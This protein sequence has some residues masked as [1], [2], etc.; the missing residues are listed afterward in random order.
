MLDGREEVERPRNNV[1]GEGFFDSTDQHGWNHYR[2]PRLTAKISR[3][4]A[5]E[6]TVSGGWCRWRD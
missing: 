6:S 3:G 4:R 5:W 1:E 2:L